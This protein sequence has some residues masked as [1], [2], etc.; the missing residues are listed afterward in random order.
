LPT[1]HVHSDRPASG[2]MAVR[3]VRAS[4]LALMIVVS[5]ALSLG[6][7]AQ[8]A[9]HPSAIPSRATVPLGAAM[10]YSCADPLD[11]GPPALACRAKPIAPQT[12]AGLAASYTSTLTTKFDRLTPEDAFKM[13]WTQ[14]GKGQFDFTVADKVAAFAR[15][16]AMNV[17]GHALIYAAA[18]PGWVNKPFGSDLPLVGFLFAWTRNSLLATMRNHITTMVTHFK[19][20]FP[21]VVDA[22]DVV[23]EP[24]LESGARDPNVYQRVI[25]DDWIEQAFRAANAADPDA[26]LYLNE[27]DADVDGPRQRAVLSLV[28]DFV[29]RGVPI[30]GVGMEMHLGADGKYPTMQEI[31]A[32]IAQ[33]AQLGVRVSITELDVLRPVRWDGGATQRAVYNSVAQACRAMPNCTDVT[34]W[35]VADGHS[36]RGVDQ[37]ATL[38]DTSFTAK[39]AYAD[40]RCRLNDPKPA[41]GAWQ[42]TP[43]GPTP[44]ATE[45]PQTTGPSGGPSTESDPPSAGGAAAP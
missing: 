10:Q 2:R 1:G 26:L 16:H 40:V 45:T 44:P 23:N 37:R 36:W 25:G 35:G 21:G 38:F 8:A 17:R 12:Q 24:F 14:P 7:R 18:N 39:P 22:W 41:T 13:V 42:P 29:S 31:K 3:C 19:S 30:D 15:A 11:G 6:S 4:T 34:V 32:V 33:Y 20:A 43:C 28:R 9:A 27:F 5:S